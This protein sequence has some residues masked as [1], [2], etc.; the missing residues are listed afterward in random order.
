MNHDGPT[1]EAHR[2]LARTLQLLGVLVRT[3]DRLG[4]VGVTCLGG[5]CWLRLL[6][7]PASPRDYFW[8][9]TDAGM[10]HHP[11]GRGGDALVSEDE[12]VATVS[13]AWFNSLGP[14]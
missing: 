14:K 6:P 9:D 3:E 4:S 7:T 8:Y 1:E 2:R 5:M 11:D 10:W 12:L 13:V